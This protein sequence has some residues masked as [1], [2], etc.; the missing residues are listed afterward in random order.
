MAAAA[1]KASNGENRPGLSIMEEPENRAGL[2]IVAIATKTVIARRNKRQFRLT[3]ID[4]RVAAIERE[5][6]AAGIS[7]NELCQCA[8]V[9]PSTWRAW[10]SGQ[11]EPKPAILE[12]LKTAIV[13][14]LANA[15]RDVTVLAALHRVV[16]VHLAQRQG[17]D[18]ELVL[19]QDFSAERP[20]SP[21]WLHAAQLRRQAM[22]LLAVEL[23]IP[24]ANIGRALGCT[25]Q[26]VKQAR[27]RIE[28]A[29]DADPAVDRT[30][31]DM[32]RLLRG[33]A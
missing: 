15:R 23:E 18:P 11:Q 30:L 21:A 31:D 5:R 24:N 16:I 19:E 28:E 1:R 13:G 4:P 9:H 25:R 10:R 3:V 27:D 6:T 14:R 2:S 32:G 26:N 20:Q 22:Y 17:A 33:V 29:R 7:H 12:R 8:R